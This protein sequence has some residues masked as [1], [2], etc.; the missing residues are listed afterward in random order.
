MSYA[1]PAGNLTDPG[2]TA[3]AWE[4]NGTVNAVVLGRPQPVAP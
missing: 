4:A 2:F 1:P 3:V